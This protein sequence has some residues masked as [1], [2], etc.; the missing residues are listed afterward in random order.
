MLYAIKKH[1]QSRKELATICGDLATGVEYDAGHQDA[2]RRRVVKHGA[3]A[4]P[5]AEVVP[6]RPAAVPAAQW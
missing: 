4:C 2:L 5:H 3:G 1:I 6:I